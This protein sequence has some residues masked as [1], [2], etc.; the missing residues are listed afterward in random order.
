MYVTNREIDHEA[1]DGTL[2]SSE[3]AVS[4]NMGYQ[5][6]LTEN[7]HAGL[8]FG[9]EDNRM[10]IRR[11]AE[12]DGTQFDIGGILKGRYGPHS[13]SFSASLGEGDYDTQRYIDLPTPNV[14]AV[15]DRN[16]TL[17]AL[18]ARY[19]FEFSG[20]NWY[21]RPLFDLGYTSV[22]TDGFT[23]IGA[24]P[25]NLIVESDRYDYTT[26]YAGLQA[27]TEWTASSGTAFRPFVRA[28]VMS[29]L[30]GETP[31]IRATLSGA[32]DGIPPFSQWFDIDENFTDVAA[33][34]DFLWSNDVSARL[35]YEGQ[36]GSS[37]DASAWYAKLVVGL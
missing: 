17:A 16:I 15:G 2:G 5:M 26:G 20:D 27:G 25:A 12:R 34:I 35:G 29:L 37:W 22:D 6:A 4:L 21:L 33:G 18:H 13:L 11:Y 8:V 3:N 10:I 9:Y 30:D 1:A 36:F 23:E 24:G 14:V 28:G 31:M 32:P 19:A 7:W